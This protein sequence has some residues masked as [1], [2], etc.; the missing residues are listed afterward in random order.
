MKKVIKRAVQSKE[1]IDMIYLSNDN[2]V[3]RRV[4]RVLTVAD[5]YVKAYCYSK[6]KVRTFKLDN[7]LSIASIRNRT[8]A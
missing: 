1:K 6:R 5:Y 3:S 4:I 8:G 2:Q 7:I